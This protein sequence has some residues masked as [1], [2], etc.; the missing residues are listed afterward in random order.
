LPAS[1]RV[2]AVIALVLALAGCAGLPFGR[3]ESAL[4][5]AQPFEMQGRVFARY[6]DRAF[7]GSIRWRH[8]NEADELW[9]GGPLGQTAAHILRDASGAALTTANQ[10]TYRS[11]NLESSM[12]DA[13]GWALPLADLSHY[14]L[15]RIPSGASDSNVKRNPEQ[16]LTSVLHNGWEIELT[17]NDQP[18]QGARPMRLRMR[19]DAVEVRIVIDQ[20]ETD[21][22]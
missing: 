13:L 11:M 4:G 3:D 1:V 7:S 16:H 17:P 10:Q 15:G 12:R 14:V 22:S 20:L 6:S 21:V 19:K 18:G 2:A 8:T 5:S 9:L